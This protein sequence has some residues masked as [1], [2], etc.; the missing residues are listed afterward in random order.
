MIASTPEQYAATLDSIKPRRND[1]RVI[2]DK[3]LVQIGDRCFPLD[4]HSGLEKF[5]TGVYW[6]ILES[7]SEEQKKTFPSFWGQLFEDYVLWLLA[8]SCADKR[9]RLY[10]NPQYAHDPRQEVCDAVVVCDQTAIFIEIKGNTIT[11]EAKYSSDVD[12]LRDEIEKK[13]VGTE[14]RRKGIRQLVTA[15]Q[16]TCR[17]ESPHAIQ[18]V[19]L[20]F[21]STAMPLLITRD[22]IGGYFGMNAYLKARFKEVF[23]RVRYQASV[24][25]CLCICSDTLEKLTPYLCDTSL[26][27]IFRSRIKNDK[28]LRA[29]FFARIGS[30]L[31]RKNKGGPDRQPTLLKDATFAV[32]EVAKEVYGVSASSATQQPHNSVTNFIRSGSP[33]QPLFGRRC[34]LKLTDCFRKRDCVIPRQT[35]PVSQRL[36]LANH[37]APQTNERAVPRLVC[38]R[39]REM[40]APPE[41]DNENEERHAE[42]RNK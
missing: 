9:N 35:G 10:K 14:R 2:R 11:S 24:A 31:Q 36:L 29:P 21:I 3:P 6:S 33:R 40:I 18:G 15:I 4:A 7:L 5:E 37:P 19:D 39:I 23:G 22:D 30:I 38:S 13:Y 12:K 17:G 32:K 41:G 26:A 1:F 16:N 34:G 28:T 20:K 25:P 27:D 8:E 42:K